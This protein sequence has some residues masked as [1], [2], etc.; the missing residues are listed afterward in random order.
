MIKIIVMVPRFNITS[1]KI[2]DLQGEFAHF[3]SV[4]QACRFNR[5]I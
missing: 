3:P 1:Q 4:Y 5:K 2:C